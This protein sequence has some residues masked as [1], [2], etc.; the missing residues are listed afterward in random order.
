MA[1]LDKLS[2]SHE[3]HENYDPIPEGLMRKYVVYA[4]KYC[5][6]KMKASA[7]KV[8]L[9]F[10]LRLR[11]EHQK[12]G[13]TPIT[14][15]QLESMIRLAEARAKVELR[16]V[17]TEEDAVDVVEIMRNSIYDVM[18]DEVGKVDYRRSKGAS[19]V[20]MQRRFKTALMNYCK[21][22]GR[23]RFPVGELKALLRNE[24]FC[25]PQEFDLLIELMNNSGTLLS[26]NSGKEYEFP[27]GKDW[28]SGTLR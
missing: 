16:Q 13:S 24:Q 8:L 6:P 21:A 5:H 17:V 15:R 26:K 14:T 1:L 9:D 10:Y 27:P 2:L 22:V 4:R 19:K 28:A 20:Q 12:E 7:K 23:N 25:K 11:R 3:E 18:A